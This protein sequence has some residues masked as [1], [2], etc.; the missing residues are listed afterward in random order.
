M[1]S[2]DRPRVDAHA[3]LLAAVILSG[4]AS[5]MYQVA[6][7]RRLAS[8]TSVTVTAQALVLSTFMAGLGLGAYWAGRYARRL[9][10]PLLA[11]AVAETLAALLAA[12]SIPLITWSDWLRTAWASAGGSLGA[13]LWVQI[14]ADCAFILIP[15][16]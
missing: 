10:Q 5:L 12:V 13:G 3:A 8:V 2:S 11:Y 9:R 15:A 6:W 7:T 14:A 1:P 4:A 16:A